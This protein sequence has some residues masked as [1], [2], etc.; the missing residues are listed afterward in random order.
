MLLISSI[1]I[2][3]CYIIHIGGV[4]KCAFLFVIFFSSLAM[5]VLSLISSVQIAFRPCLDGV[6]KGEKCTV[7]RFGFIWQKMSNYLNQTLILS[8][9]ISRSNPYF[10]IRFC[11]IG[12]FILI[13]HSRCLRSCFAVK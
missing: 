3:T 13:K 7:A 9:V 2:V 1:D 4:A 11:Y 6:K 10:D 8:V 12:W 5:M